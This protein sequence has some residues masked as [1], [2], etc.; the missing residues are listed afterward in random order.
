[1][2]QLL[3]KSSNNYKLSKNPILTYSLNLLPAKSSNIINTCSHATKVCAN[4]C[5][6]F[7]GR[8]AFSNVH[9]SRLEK[10]RL[11]ATD[12]RGFYIQLTNEI[13]DITR[14]AIKKGQRVAIRLN[15]YSDIPHIEL[16]K[17]Y[18]GVDLLTAPYCD[19][20]YMY[21]YTKNP[22]QAIKYLNT[23]YRLTFSRSESNEAAAL[24]ILATG[25]N[26]AVVFRNELPETWHGF[27]VIDG[28]ETDARFLDPRGVVVG[29]RAKGK[30]AKNDVSGFVVDINY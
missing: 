15:C 30:R 14:K 22:K 11:F 17:R 2:K 29:L 28:D 4:L 8:G 21:D 6:A 10:T 9:L 1:M 16:I 19:Y 23:S 24:E 20:L 18:T 26:V 12:R 13:L 5:V 3:T 7:C 25:G 27:N